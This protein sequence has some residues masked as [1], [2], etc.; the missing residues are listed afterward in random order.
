MAR[1]GDAVLLSP[2]CSSFDMFRN[3]EHRAEVFRAAVKAFIAGG[4]V[5]AP[6]RRG[7]PMSLRER[8]AG[9]AGRKRKASCQRRDSAARTRPFVG[10]DHPGLDRVRGRD[11]VLGGR[12][13]RGQDLTATGPTSSSAR[14]FYSGAG[15][16]AFALGM[17]LDYSVY[18]PFRLSPALPVHGHAGRGVESG[19]AING[20][21]RW[22]RWA[23]LSFQPSELAKFSLAL[24][25]AVLLA[26]QGPRGS[27]TSAW[28]FCRPPLV[29]RG[30]S[31]CCCSKQPDLALRSSWG[32]GVGPAVRGGHAHQLHFVVG[33]GWLRP[34]AGR[35]SLPASPGA[36]GAFSPFSIPG[37]S[38]RHGYQALRSLIRRGLRRSLGPGAGTGPP[39]TL[40]PARSPHRLHF[41]H[42]RRGAGPVR[43]VGGLAGVQRCWCGAV[44]AR[45]RG[46]ATPWGAI[47]HFP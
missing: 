9:R 45:P 12:G 29:M 13:V 14:R 38:P 43:R 39:E 20:A 24:Y 6:A 22:F 35:C 30:S 17:R 36:C 41:G 19:A 34:S 26:R 40:F 15:L 5:A 32:H 46:H 10:R 33:A 23:A 25:L 3:Y 21:V 1:S 44:C 4:A 16:L 37:S 18:R 11:G 27:R 7:I 2:A 42:H 31:F 28:D 47:W 8:I